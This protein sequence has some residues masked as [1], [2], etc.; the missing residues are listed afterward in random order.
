MSVEAVETRALMHQ[1]LKAHFA[2]QRS[3]RSFSFGAPST[4]QPAQSTSSLFGA[5]TSTAPSTTPS[6]FGTQP[7]AQPGA[8]SSGLFGASSASKPTFSFG[9]APAQQNAAPS[10]TTSLFG[11]SAQTPAGQSG[12]SLFSVPQQQQPSGTQT[13]SLPLQSSS[14]LLTA[15][16]KFNDLS[17]A[18]RLAVEGIDNAV[19]AQMQ[20]A[21]DL[22]PLALGESIQRIT[23][24]AEQTSVEA[25]AIVS[26]LSQDL[27]ATADLRTRLDNDLEVLSNVNTIIEACKNPQAKGQ[28][29]TSL[30]GYPNKYFSSKAFE[31]REKLE[32]YGSALDIVQHQISS[33]GRGEKSPLALVS[34]LRAQHASFM[35]LA[36]A[37]AALDL[38]LKQV[39][40]EYRTIWRA[41]TSSV[42]DPFRQVDRSEL[43]RS[44]AGVAIS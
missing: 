31:F 25:T 10:S 44:F 40:D 13:A 26:L 3:C 1:N 28:A 27:K 38:Q 43:R 2:P 34:T 35:A 12:T 14:S 39:K 23:I 30:A 5:P 19:R 37:V 21:D 33:A 36:S 29:A 18:A 6:L 24:N 17:D 7:L 16:S 9:A 8:S 22:R 32:R 11:A 42:Q 41:K 20:M 4:S 15:S